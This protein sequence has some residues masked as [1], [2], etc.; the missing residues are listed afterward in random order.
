[1]AALVRRVNHVLEVIVR[2]LGGGAII[3]VRTQLDVPLIRK[4]HQLLIHHFLRVVIS[5]GELS[6]GGHAPLRA[7][8]YQF[9]L[10]LVLRVLTVLLA[11][12]F[13]SYR[14]VVVCRRESVENPII[15]DD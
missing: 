12:H 13:H 1:M 15:V 5:G 8:T 6:F 14:R 9:L 2:L 4:L 10:A 7:S 11:A 3:L